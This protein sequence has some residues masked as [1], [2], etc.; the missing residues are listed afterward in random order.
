MR[1]MDKYYLLRFPFYFIAEALLSQINP[2]TYYIL[3]SG[4]IYIVLEVTDTN[5]A[6]YGKNSLLYVD[7]HIVPTRRALA[8]KHL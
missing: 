4:N 7:K 1:L 3:L 8:Y 2:Y 5:I 6:L